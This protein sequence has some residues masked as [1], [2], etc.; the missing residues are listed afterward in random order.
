MHDRERRVI[1]PTKRFGYVDHIN[2]AFT[3]TK[4]IDKLE[5]KNF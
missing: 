2:Y 5:P 1:K 3:T 4:K